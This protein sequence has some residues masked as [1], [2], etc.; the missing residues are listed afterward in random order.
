MKTNHDNEIR[1]QCMDIIHLALP[2]FDASAV[3]FSA[4]I[5][6]TE[7]MK[8]KRVIV[9]G[10]GDSYLAAV[11]AAGAFKKY[12]HGTGCV[13][14]YG[15][16]ID[17]ARYWPLHQSGPET[18]IVAVSASGGPARITEILGRGNKYGCI[19]V[20]L[21]NTPGS[22]AAQAAKYTYYTNTPP[23]PDQMPGLRNYFA[24]LVSLFVMAAAMGEKLGAK[25]GAVADLRKEI[26]AYNAGYG[27][28]LKYIDEAAFA[29]ADKWKDVKGFEVVADGPLF[30]CGEFIAAK[31][32]E[33]SGDQCTVIDSE[34]YCHVNCLL[35][36]KDAF[37]TYALLLGGAA[38]AAR[39]AETVNRQVT[40]EGRKVW[41]VA[42]RPAKELGI[43]EPV[44]ECLVP[45]PPQQFPFIYLLYG[46]IP[47][48]LAA[49]YH[50]SLIA[51]PYF[52]GGGKFFS[53]EINTLKT[54]KIKII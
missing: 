39:I 33:V 35:C 26:A 12:L 47:G 2:Q 18:M 5:P 52:R 13:M 9:T 34:N 10:C 31:Y 14:E 24:S 54:S 15:R 46:Y 45:S 29:I 37:G 25:R 40:S 23:F 51:E 41:V 49:G 1:R 20:A 36:P 21:T 44:D 28:R 30:A 6:D 42:D 4:L 38:N 22:S 50:A 3:S 43:T 19:T 11:E 7:L 16:A 27:G 48:A 17:V 53:P 32:A 8:I